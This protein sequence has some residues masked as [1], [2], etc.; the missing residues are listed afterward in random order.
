MFNPSRLKLA[1][2]SRGLNKTGVAKQLRVDLRSITA[3]EKGEF[4][5]SPEK[6]K[7]LADFLRFPVEFFF[8]E[9]LDVPS[10]QA[11]SF[12]SM[13]RMTAAKRD[14]ALGAGALAFLLN[15]WIEAHFE[16]PKADLLD[17][18]DEEPEAAAA[19][20]RQYWG[21]GERPIRNMVHL[22]EVKGVRI[23][24]LAAQAVE[25]DA[26]SLWRGEKPFIF[27]NTLKTAEHGRFDAA[28]ELGHLVLHRH[29]SPSGQGAEKDANVFA[30]AF[31]MPRGSVLSLSRR[32]FTLKHLI[33]LK[34]SWIVSVAALNYRL[35]SVGVLSDWHYRT[36]CIEISKRGYRKSEPEG[37]SRETSQILAKVF[38]TLRD[39][40][41]SKAVVAEQIKLDVE[42]LDRM[43]FGLILLGLDGGSSEGSSAPSMRPLLRVIK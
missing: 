34:K 42:E 31:L 5:P 15:D 11:A 24:S 38:A 3:Y 28:H 39:E 23:Y 2:K 36:L 7:Q 18:R 19:M 37:A 21:I 30:S 29:G 13:S 6:L 33:E 25:V 27:L 14:A 12:R 22:L 43:V 8:G 17:L 26:F 20:L 1:R 4:P 32:M 16:L 10:T 41:V 35:H 40:G 9:D